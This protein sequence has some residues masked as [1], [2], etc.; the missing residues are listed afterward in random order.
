MCGIRY[1][2]TMTEREQ[3]IANDSQRDAELDA[4]AEQVRLDDESVWYRDEE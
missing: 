2:E 4:I 1:E 3:E